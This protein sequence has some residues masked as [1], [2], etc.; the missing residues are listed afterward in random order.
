MRLLPAG[1]VGLVVAGFIAS[2]M[3]S[4]AS[5]LNSA[6][7]LITMDVVRPLAPSLSDR[8]IVRVG[9]WCTVVLLAAAVAW[10]P[11]LQLFPSLWQ[12]LQAVLAYVVPPVVALFLCGLFWRSAT[13][14]AASATMLIG[15]FCGLALFL[16]NV[17]LRWTHLH[18]LYAAPLLTAV[19]VAILAVVSSSGVSGAST[20]STMWQANFGHAENPRAVPFWRDYRFLGAGLLMLTAAIVVMFR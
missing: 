2:T 7:T 19:D 13:A 16:T 17:V 15:S 5:M 14:D 18:F 1:L 12:Y 8:R 10:A 11:Q 20:A 6:S 4:I 3:V 9:Q